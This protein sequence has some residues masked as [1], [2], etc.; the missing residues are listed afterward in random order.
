VVHNLS[1][2]TLGLELDLI[3]WKLN[4][5]VLPYLLH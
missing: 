1:E 3:G 5:C 2:A 4:L